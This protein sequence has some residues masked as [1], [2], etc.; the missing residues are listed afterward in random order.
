MTIFK[1]A[2]VLA[3]AA[4][5]AMAISPT[6]TTATEGYFAH[7]WGARHS[8]LAG[9][10]IANVTDASGQ[11]HNPAG[12]V[13]VEGSELNLA[14]S[15]FNPNRAYEASGGPGFA[16]YG[17]VE[18]GKNLH[19]V[20]NVAYSS[21][22]DEDSAWGIT[23]YGNGGM[24]TQYPAFDRPAPDC[25][26]SPVGGNGVYCAGALG[27]DLLQAFLSVTYASKIGD[28]S[29]GISPVVAFQAFE[30]RGLGAFAGFSSDPANFTNN[31]HDT[32]TGFGAKIGLG[33]KV[34]DALDIAVSYQS[35]IDMSELEDY[36]GLFADGG[37]FDIPSNLT[38]GVAFH[39]DEDL[40]F[41]LDWKQINYT[42][43]G[44]VSN[45]GAEQVPFGFPGGP[46]FGWDDVTAIKLAVEWQT[47]ET[48]TWRFG[49]AENDNPIGPEDVALN[50]LA[51]GVVTTHFSTGF[52]LDLGEG[53]AFEFAFTYVPSEE[54]TGYGMAMNNDVI[55]LEMDQMI[56]GFSWT[57]NMD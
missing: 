40:T 28:F 50:I 46:G 2:K 34:S 17:R 48:M 51:P 5:V 16:A 15:L 27:V 54:V 57:I 9:A 24:N 1:K 18:S 45:S 38:I 22:I 12:L 7:G 20:P 21:S 55:T 32:S 49:Y 13:N 52:E 14:I 35:K 36:A 8:A 23:F 25:P 47:S 29:W 6:I 3:V 43:A 44:S 39:A 11:A 4:G 56:M 26:P 10:G 30:A 31:S 41:M 53:D 19:L 42:D 37:D 33:Y